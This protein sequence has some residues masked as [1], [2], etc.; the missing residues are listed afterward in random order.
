MQYAQIQNGFGQIYNTLANVRDTEVNAKK[1]INALQKTLS[2]K[3]IQKN[4]ELYALACSNLGNAYNTLARV[5]DIE[6]NA[7][8]AI[9]IF[10]KAL[11]IKNIQKIPVAYITH[12]PHFKTLRITF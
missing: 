9:D 8:K 4:I 12:I 11:E 6:G 2:V 10:H 3:N 1:A 5:R 7:T